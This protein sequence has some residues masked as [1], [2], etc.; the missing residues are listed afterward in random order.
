MRERLRG[1][2]PR[3]TVARSARLLN[4]SARACPSHAFRLKQ[5]G[6]DEQDEEAKVWKT[7]M[8]IERRGN[9]EKRSVRTLIAI[10][11]P[12]KKNAPRCP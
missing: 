10:D 1:T 7:L 12:T 2:G 3:T 11:L 5:D 9:T 8:S 6:Q 4:R